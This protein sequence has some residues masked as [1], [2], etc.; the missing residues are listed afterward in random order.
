VIHRLSPWLLAALLVGLVLGGNSGEARPLQVVATFS[1]LQDFVQQ[2]GGEAVAVQALV[3]LGADPHTWE[4][5][6]RDAVLLAKADLVVANGAGFDDWLLPLVQGAVRP[7]VPVILL[8]EEGMSLLAGGHG[9]HG[10]EHAADPHLWLSVANAVAYVERIADVL[11]EL[12]P[13][14]E[15][16][17]AQRSG[18]YTT[19]LWALD[20]KLEKELGRIPAENRVIVTYHN[21]FSYLAERYGFSVAE[22]LVENPEAEPNPRE[23]GRLVGLLQSLGRPVVFTEPQLTSGTRYM[24]TLAREAGAQVFTLYSDSLTAEVPT[25]ID[26]MEHNL[27]VL[28]EALQ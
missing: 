3:P 25:Y 14:Q 5:S 27:Q 4:P 13:E 17:F 11:R 9:N 16:Y 28:L 10:H 18:D 1:I 15:A 24:Q 7:G 2:V 21:A 22:F 26:M 19:R 20:E 8:A 6:P 12:R 23:L